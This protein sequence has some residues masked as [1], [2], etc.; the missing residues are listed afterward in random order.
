MYWVK[1]SFLV[2]LHVKIELSG[3]T[4]IEMMLFIAFHCKLVDRVNVQRHKSRDVDVER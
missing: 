2:F 4:L 1:V 3:C